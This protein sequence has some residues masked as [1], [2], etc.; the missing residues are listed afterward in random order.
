VAGSARIRCANRRKRSSA[1]GKGRGSG[2]ATMLRLAAM[3][4]A[5][6][7]SPS[8]LRATAT[9]VPAAA[10]NKCCRSQ[11]S[12]APPSPG[13]VHNRVKSIGSPSFRWRHNAP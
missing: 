7:G 3:H 8:T 11:R 5:I 9:P 13:R 1:A 10:M 6:A 4:A 2:G 12:T